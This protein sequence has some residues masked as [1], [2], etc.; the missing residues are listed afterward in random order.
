MALYGGRY[1]IKKYIR[2]LFS[3]IEN[4]EYD[5]AK[6]VSDKLGFSLKRY[7]ISRNLNSKQFDEYISRLNYLLLSIFRSK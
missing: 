4:K 7:N 3:L 5:Q 1:E 6:K 2:Q